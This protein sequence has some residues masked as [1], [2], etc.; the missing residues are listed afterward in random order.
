MRSGYLSAQPG[1][2]AN[3]FA[4]GPLGLID[5][6]EFGPSQTSNASDFTGTPSEPSYGVSRDDLNVLMQRML[7]EAASSPAPMG[8]YDPREIRT[9]PDISCFKRPQCVSSDGS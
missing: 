9:L 7:D 1:W 8:L 5:P 6:R 4:R 2:L 3:L